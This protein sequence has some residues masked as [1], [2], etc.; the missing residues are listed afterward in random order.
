MNSTTAP[1]LRDEGGFQRAGLIRQ[2]PEIE[3]LLSKLVPSHHQQT[4]NYI[5]SPKRQR[6]AGPDISM[7]ERISEKTA[8]NIID[9]QNLLQ[10]LPDVEMAMQVTVSAILA[11][12]DLIESVVSWRVDPGWIPS[13]LTQ[14]M[15]D[16]IRDHFN[17]NYKISERLPDILKDVL[18]LRGSRPILLLPESSID[19][20]INSGDRISTESL[21][22]LMSENKKYFKPLGFLGNRTGKSNVGL[23]SYFE[24]RNGKYQ[25]A[26]ESISLE[27]DVRSS[28]LEDSKRHVKWT[29]DPM[30]SVVDNPQV[31]LLPT[32]LEK[33]RRDKTHD[34]IRP[35]GIGTEAFDP[36]ETETTQSG[37]KKGSLFRARRFNQVQTAMVSKPSH[38]SKESIGHPTEINLPS[39]CVIPVHVPSDP[40]K[41]LGYF[42]MIDPQGNPLVKTTE[43]DYFNEMAYNIRTN[44][45][46]T[47][48]MITN[49]GRHQNPDADWY[50]RQIDIA[51]MTR[52]YSDLM[53]HELNAR[54]KNGLYG[55][56]VKVARPQEIYQIM[57]A[58]A[59]AGMQT[60]L[61]YVP[62]E[63]MTYVAFDYNQYGI[64]VSLLQ[65]SKILGGLRAIMLFADIMAGIKNSIGNTVV[66]IQLDEE[67]PDPVTT[68]ETIMHEF[69]YGRSSGMMPLGT[70]RPRDIVNYM[71][72]ASVQYSVSGNNRL[73]TVKV[74]AEDKPNNR[75]R[76]DQQLQD[77]LKKNH[78]NALGVSPETVDASQGPDFATT[79]VANNLMFAKRVLIWQKQLLSFMQDHIVK[80]TLNSS[81]LMGRLR[82]IVEKNKQLIDS[83]DHDDTD[84]EDNLTERRI[85][86]RASPE[87]QDADA[88]IIDFL[89][90]LR[91]ELPKPDQGS[92]RLQKE[93]F[94]NQVSM[95]ESA[96]KFYIDSSFLKEMELGEMTNQLDDI[97]EGVKSYFMR[98]WMRSENIFPELNIL[99]ELD[100]DKPALD[101]TEAHASHI[102][103]LRKSVGNYI[104]KVV[105]D[106]KA[107]EE[108]AKQDLEAAGVGGGSSDDYGSNDDNQS[109]G[110]EGGMDDDFSMDDDVDN[111]APSAETESEAE[112]EDTSDEDDA[113]E[114]D[115]KSDQDDEE[116]ASGDEDDQEDDTST[117]SFSDAVLPYRQKQ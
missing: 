105:A 50:S 62:A 26:V 19:H 112:T 61:L 101:M 46:L 109:S 13:D 32:V 92:K 49:V 42:I 116:K 58:R 99:T 63:L 11:P 87:H 103:L 113:A 43:M 59:L 80:Y 90:A 28:P 7:M 14:P 88:I 94:D 57:F 84:S 5:S 44:R 29:F 102:E 3:A 74:S 89:N 39:E 9:A 4:Q 30:V 110:D 115:D 52:L 81:V 6:I 31:L 108:K 96:L 41:H 21:T 67:D 17:Q 97:I 100:G 45:S 117:E 77:T 69:A 48:Q 83:V 54:L 85:D 35:K 12:K 8:T 56:Q 64:G 76:P 53:E 93:E 47:D 24:N 73:P 2:D 82:D 91:M 55:D 78:L 107:F 10:T 20:L 86:Y 23:E 38:L 65:K 60:Q 66:D 106:L 18:Y 25:P 111:E 71:K 22:A 33:L 34:I 40:E 51:E 98:D 37:Q 72:Q 27:F 70:T 15:L 68:L 114:T 1:L 104:N 75:V 16:V 95:L 79:V 36:I